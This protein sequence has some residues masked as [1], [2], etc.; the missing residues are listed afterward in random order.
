MI[1]NTIS[2]DDHDDV[3]TVPVRK[4]DHN[5]SLRFNEEW[6]REEY[7]GI[8]M[9]VNQ[10]TGDVATENPFPSTMI[11]YSF[12]KQ[13]SSSAKHFTSTRNHALKE[14]HQQKS[15]SR[16]LLAPITGVKGIS[17]G[18]P[19]IIKMDSYD[20]SEMNELFRMLD[21]MKKKY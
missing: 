5:P 2:V 8:K 13:K 10:F 16:S 14:F 21:D 15:K 4:L 3:A 11:P 18:N 1:V 6:K 12:S 7:G 20:H 19:P 17:K 9:W